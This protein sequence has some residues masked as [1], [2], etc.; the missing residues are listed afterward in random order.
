MSRDVSVPSPPGRPALFA[1]ATIGLVLVAACEPTDPA[2]IPDAV[3]QAELGLTERDRVYTV[4]VRTGVGERATPDSVVV[5]R[6]DFVQFVSDD[7]FVHEVRFQL[8]AL[9]PAQRAFLTE[10]GQDASS[11]LLRRGARFVLT[12]LDAPPGSYPYALEGNRAPGSGV[13]VVRD[14]ADS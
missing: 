7:H 4:T 12:L 14:P 2:L 9:S 3:L 13:L 6:G 5:E 11:P 8:D 1:L 10:T